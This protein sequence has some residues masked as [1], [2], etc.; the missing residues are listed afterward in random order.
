MFLE[1]HFVMQNKEHQTTSS[2][3]IVEECQPVNENNV[4]VVSECLQVLRGLVGLIVVHRG[5]LSRGASGSGE[6]RQPGVGG[7][8]WN[9]VVCRHAGE[10]VSVRR[11]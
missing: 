6:W 9:L 3:Q 2:Y 5:V 8:G 11:V 7:R 10:G 1:I 4:I